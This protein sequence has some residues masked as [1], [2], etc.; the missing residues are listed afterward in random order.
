LFRKNQPEIAPNT[1]SKN[2][3]AAMKFFFKM[4]MLSMLTVV[5]FGSAKK[6]DHPGIRNELVDLTLE[7][8]N[9]AGSKDLLLNSGDY[10]NSSGE[11]LNVSQLQY[12][13]S[14]IKFNGR[15]GRSFSVKQDESYF[16][17]QEQE[18]ATQT[19]KLKVPPG[20][21]NKVTFVLGVDSLRNTMPI[22]K[23][24]GVLDPSSSM[25]NGMYWSWNSGYIFFKMEGTSDAAPEDP[26]GNRRFRFHIG[27]FGGYSAPTINNIKSVTLDLSKQGTVKAK[28]GRNATIYIK[29]DILKT[30]NGVTKLSIAAHPSVMF[31]EYSVNVANNYSKMFYH[32]RTVN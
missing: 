1:V 19:I 15:N 11:S 17:I 6:E 8:D 10:T 26:T 22:D 24:K 12:F 23:R 28:K 20:E 5:V 25:D 2:N 16:L 30:F 14:N 29:A 13:I 9:V 27:G 7:F 21:Y 31:S 32:D 3:Q 4:T 18:A